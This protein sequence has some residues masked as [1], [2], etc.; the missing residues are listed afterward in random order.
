MLAPKREGH[1]DRRR[2]SATRSRLP[3]A[4]SAVV[5]L[6]RKRGDP[7]DAS[8]SMRRR[9]RRPMRA[10]V[11]VST[12]ALGS[13]AAMVGLMWLTFAR[14]GEGLF[15]MLVVSLVFATFAVVPLIVF[16]LA[17]RDIAIDPLSFR[18]YLERSMDTLTGRLEGRAAL[19][20]IIGVPA[21]LTLCLVGIA[22]AVAL[23]R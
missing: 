23:A 15:V 11:M 10:G 12:L 14:T 3:T 17:R 6:W 19:V 8:T 18:Q 16:R 7:A 13:Y 22:I 21:L 1:R 5:E 20:Q 4:R 9:Q 2:K